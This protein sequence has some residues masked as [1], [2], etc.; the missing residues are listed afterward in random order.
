MFVR[1]PVE[2]IVL[3]RPPIGSTRPD[4]LLPSSNED[5]IELLIR[6]NR[7]NRKPA[8]FVRSSHVSRSPLRV[9]RRGMDR[10]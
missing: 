1:L 5:A 6:S 9:E 7:L 3:M 2:H 8:V 4:P 10:S